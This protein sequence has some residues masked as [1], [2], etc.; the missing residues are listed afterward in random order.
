MVV[1]DQKTCQDWYR[2]AG[3]REV[4]HKVFLCAGYKDGGRD[5]CQVRPGQLSGGAGRAVRRSRD[6]CQVRPGQLPVEART[7]VK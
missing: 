5:S 7:A 2:G 4:I 6:N 1:I 3:R